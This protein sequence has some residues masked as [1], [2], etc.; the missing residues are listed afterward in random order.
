MVERDDLIGKCRREDIAKRQRE[1][2]RRAAKLEIGEVEEYLLTLFR[3][4]DAL[5]PAIV[6]SLYAQHRT[7]RQNLAE[8]G[9]EAE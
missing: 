4:G 5:T 6:G 3:N 8:L 1:Q 2:A 7:A 9:A